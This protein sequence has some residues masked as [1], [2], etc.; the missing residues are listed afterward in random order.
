MKK[1]YSDPN[2]RF[3]THFMIKRKLIFL[4]SSMLM[5]CS[6]APYHVELGPLSK[7]ET[8]PKYGEGKHYFIYTFHRFVSRDDVE[9]LNAYYRDIEHYVEKNMPRSGNC[10]VIKETLSYYSEGG[11][12]SIL[13]VC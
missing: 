13:V 11:S 6:Q 4:I 8:V 10:R 7:Q 5:A 9:A 3:K 12:V 2:I 1:N